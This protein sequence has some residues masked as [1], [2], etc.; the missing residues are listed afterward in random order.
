M[1]TITDNPSK[2]RVMKTNC[3]LKAC[4]FLII[5]TLATIQPTFSTPI[6][7]QQAQKNVSEFLQ[8]K[9]VNVKRLSMRHAPMSQEEE[10][11]PYYVFN[12]GDDNGFVIA[13]GDD[14]AYSIL[15][16]SD[17]GHLDTDSMPD[18]MKYMLD[19][20]AQQIAAAPETA[21]SAKKKA[22]TSYPAV[23]PMLTTTWHQ[24]YPYNANCPLEDGERCVTG[25][26][27]TAMAQV[28]YYHRKKSTDKVLKRI[29]S[30]N[31]GYYHG[32]TYEQK[33]HVN[34]VPKGS[35]IDWDNM[36][37]YYKNQDYTE[38]QAQAVANLMLYCGTSLDMSYGYSSSST[39]T[40]YIANALYEYFNYKK[41]DYIKRTYYSDKKWEGIICDNLTK[42]YPVIYGASNHCFVI[43]GYDGNG[44][45]HVNWGWGGN[46]DDYFLLS[47]VE[48]S[49]DTPLYGFTRNQEAIIYAEPDES[50]LEAM[51]LSIRSNS[52]VENISSL[53][54]IP[55]EIDM[56]VKN[57]SGES[58]SY[59]V[60]FMPSL[61]GE[62]LPWFDEVANNLV[63]I[64]IH[65]NRTLTRNYSIPTNLKQGLYKL[66]PCYSNSETLTD[67]S[68]KLSNGFSYISMVIK[69][70][71]ASFYIGDPI[72]GGDI[73]TFEDERVK[74]VCIDNWDYNGDGELSTEELACVTQLGHFGGG[75]MMK[76]FNE[77]RYFTGLTSIGREA[78]YYARNLESVI[79]PENVTSIEYAAFKSTKLSSIIIPENV[80]TIGH[81]AF[82]D[83]RLSSI[84]IPE[85]V[86]TI[87]YGAFSE[88][89][90]SSI[91]IPKN[92]RSVSSGAFI[93]TPLQSITVDEDN[94]W[95][96]SRNDCNAIVET[97]SNAL[98]VGCQNTV[99]PEDIL[100]IES[101]AFNGCSNLKSITIPESVTQIKDVAFKATGLYSISIP[102]NVKSIGYGAF[103]Y[104]SLSSIEV[105]PDNPWYDSRYD[106]NAI[107]KTATNELIAGCRNTIV[108]DD[109]KTVGMSAFEGMKGLSHI[110]LPIS[111]ESIG[112][113]AFRESDISS[114]EIWGVNDWF[115]SWG[116]FYDCDNL[117]SIQVN[118]AKPSYDI[119]DD[120]SPF[121]YHSYNATLYVPIGSKA[122]Y[123]KAQVW[124]N[125]SN[126]VERED[127]VEFGDDQVKQICVD[128]W[129]ISG[130]GEVSR[131]ELSQVKDLNHAFAFFSHQDS[132]P[133]PE[134][135][136]PMEVRRK[137]SPDYNI[138]TFH[139]LS[140]FTSLT[141]ID[142]YEFQ[143]AAFWAVSLPENLTK[144]GVY[145][146]DNLSSIVVPKH[147][148]SIGYKAFGDHLEYI[149]VSPY[150][151]WY[152]SRNDCNAIIETATNTL[153]QGC[154]R[155]VIPD[156]VE[157]IGVG[158]F[159]YCE[160]SSITIPK[161]VREIGS[162]MCGLVNSIKVNWYQPIEINED[163]FY[164]PWY[165][166][167]I[168]ESATLYVPRGTKAAYQAAEG[169]KRFSK[170]E[171]YGSLAGDVNGDGVVNI[172]DVTMTVNHVL[173]N[174]SESFDET[175]ADMNDDGKINISDVSLIVGVVLNGQQ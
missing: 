113:Q 104:T 126:I 7:R 123:E 8:G 125:F 65:E 52:V 91:N 157:I 106:C 158:A 128:N 1:N 41:P 66:V 44:Y 29:P 155:T 83:S 43:D 56:E 37:D 51:N 87:E 38:E 80:T 121:D 111:V 120:D 54:F 159:D 95:Y 132:S 162:F 156:D 75:G 153:I 64:P 89:K 124:R 50:S 169:W 48:G 154:M 81:S 63:N 79:I 17:S 57:A 107:I 152:D 174:H 105:N 119:F 133:Y 77:L 69:D 35:P 170:I 28:M 22:A 166:Y 167:E 6:T 21:G 129:D 55:I 140:Y 175:V 94:P 67:D 112:S 40:S 160:F 116:V 118:I 146:F 10:N 97:S 96:D 88:T 150:N 59:C 19:F 115:Y 71:K 30:Y 161:S 145:A 117:T 62:N 101:N 47:A 93:G 73:V 122:A 61:D 114:I 53:N 86:T 168:Y 138:N 84:I 23:E 102:K 36:L 18:G 82:M 78:F 172:T 99:I 15:G 45:V 98:V 76:S 49:G 70:D 109:V 31:I 85:S 26:V 20:Y 127:T 135:D 108:P 103:S 110:E 60:G 90:L 4:L 58:N 92:V 130:D 134:E 16:Y 143:G 34:A 32:S 24:T 164:G 173:G 151:K 171:E 74:E 141:S 5:G 139:E 3:Y 144:I 12:I 136:G 131:Y 9:G 46:S 39:Y 148:E 33:M 2:K 25:C 13:A 72:L 147:V 11:A 149:S 165:K 100:V 142:D 68:H 14:R 42:G 163:V 137:E 27:A